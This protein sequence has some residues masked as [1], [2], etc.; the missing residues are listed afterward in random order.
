MG[1][2]V[3]RRATITPL[4]VEESDAELLAR[5]AAGETAALGTLYDR[6]RESVHGFVARASGSAHDADDVTH[7]TFLTVAKIASS[8]DGRLSCRPWLL[9][10]AARTLGHR[11]RGA[12]RLARFLGRLARMTAGESHDP[13]EALDARTSLPRLERALSSLSD[14][15]RVVLIMFEVEAMSGEEIALALS[16]PIGTVWTRLHSARRELRAA[17]GETP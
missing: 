6:H 7:T 2:E 14:A 16:I 4:P 8:Y 9:G 13:R 5:L 1:G 11:R 17:M 3:K 10:I 15:K 12:A